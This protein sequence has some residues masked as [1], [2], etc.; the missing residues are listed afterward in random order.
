MGRFF[1]MVVLAAGV[2]AGYGSAFS[3]GHSCPHDR[4]A[5]P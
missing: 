5:A 4:A 1:L 3:G 2:V